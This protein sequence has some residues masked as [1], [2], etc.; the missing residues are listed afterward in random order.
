M[1][2]ICEI[3][4]TGDAQRAAGHSRLAGQAR[5][6]IQPLVHTS[7]HA[8]FYEPAEEASAGPIQS[9]GGRPPPHRDAGVRE[10]RCSPHR[11]ESDELSEALSAFRSIEGDRERLRARLLSRRR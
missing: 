8:D 1:S 3:A 2:W 11:D 9:R 7:Y 5:A 6:A 4:V 10:R